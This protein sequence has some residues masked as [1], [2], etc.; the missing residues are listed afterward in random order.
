MLLQHI[1]KIDRPTEVVIF[2]HICTFGIFQVSQY[3]GTW[4]IFGFLARNVRFWQARFL[5]GTL[6]LSH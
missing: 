6:N 5:P 2:L 1:G 4:V 3:I